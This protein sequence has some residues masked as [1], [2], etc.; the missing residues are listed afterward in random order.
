MQSKQQ[1]ESIIFFKGEPISFK[2][3]SKLIEIDEKIVKEI[4]MQLSEEYLEKGIRLVYNE[5]ECEIVT[6]PESSELISK[7]QKEETETDLSNAALETLSI[8]LY[9]GPIARSM[10]DFIRG[11]N[12]QFTIRNLLI[13]GLIERDPKEKT[14]KYICTLDTIKFL[15]LNK[16][17]E[18][19]N[20]IEIKD[21]ISQFI[22]ENSTED[23]N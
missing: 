13:R 11:V 16:T 15:G 10:I 9:M 23:G 6:A 5:H 1:I 22:K 17:N 4:V 12:S 21:N 20:Y 18:L 2:E 14:P 7:L 19:P 3:I 8:I